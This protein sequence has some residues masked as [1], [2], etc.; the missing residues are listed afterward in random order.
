MRIRD[1]QT[2]L[3]LPLPPGEVF[4]FFADAANLDT[5]TPPLAVK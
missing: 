3:S 2:K 1:F 4:P 5:I